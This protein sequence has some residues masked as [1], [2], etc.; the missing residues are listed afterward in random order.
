MVLRERKEAFL[1]RATAVSR[2]RTGHVK[3]FPALP[4]DRGV[5]EAQ[6]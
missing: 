2:L 3:E 6:V 4:D 5:R 1:Q